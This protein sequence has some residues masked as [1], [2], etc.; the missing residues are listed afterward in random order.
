MDILIGTTNPAKV[1]RFSGLLEGRGVRL[2]TLKDLGITRE[3][4]ETGNSPL[5]NAI[6]KAKFYGESFDRVV[7]NDSGL[8]IGGLAEDDPLQPGLH[9]RTPFGVRLNDEE[10]IAHYARLIGSLGGRRQ[11]FYRDG[12]ATY[13]RGEVQGFM[14]DEADA[15][16]GA[17]DMVSAV[18]PLRRPGWPL[19]SLSINRATGAYFV[20]GGNNLDGGT[21]ENVLIGDSRA[22]LTAFLLHAFGLEGGAS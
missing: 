6:L 2:L 9:A 1:A 10:M 11:C 3:P 15:Q 16:A 7:C 20:E 4:E 13:N 22:R 12:I 21:G 8:Y 18:H 5:E 14:E 17:F 19:D